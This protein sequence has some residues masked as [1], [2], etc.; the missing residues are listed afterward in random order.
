[1]ISDI[2]SDLS[3]EP[4]A[5]AIKANLYA[6]FRHLGHAAAAS[7]EESDGLFRW[8]TAVA[9]PWFSGVISTS[10]PTE[11]AAERI[12][13][14]MAYFRPRAAA[15]FTWWVAPPAEQSAW[16]PH[17]RSLGFQHDDHTPGM[18]IDLAALPPQSPGRLTIQTVQG[19]VALADWV[20]TFVRG[21]ELPQHMASPLLA[22]VDSLGTGLPFR[23]YLGSLDGTPVAAS[24]LFVGAGVAGIYN[25][26]TIPEARGQGFGSTLTLAPLYEARDMGLRAGALQSSDIGYRV[27]ERLG[28]RRLCQMDH[29]YCPAQAGG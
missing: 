29:F 9:H 18:A 27:Y 23:Y 12:Q 21:Y 26:A 11:Q 17:L 10:Q 5:D 15:G 6:F 3:P 7:V 19:G 24:A 22:L 20:S 1:M 13:Q 8:Q 4:L 14:T 2:L 28:F 25:V 16:A